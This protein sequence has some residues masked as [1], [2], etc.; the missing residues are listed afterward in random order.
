MNAVSVQYDYFYDMHTQALPSTKECNKF[1]SLLMDWHIH[2]NTRTLPWKSTHDPYKIW[3][4]EILLQQTRTEQGIPYYEKFITHYPTIKDLAAADDTAVFK[5]WEG[6]GYYNRCK[7]M[8]A[9]ARYIA[10][11]LD[12]VFPQDY[13]QILALKGVGAYTAAAIASF[14]FQLPH[15]VVDGNVYRVLSRY[16][17]IETPIDSHEG[18][19]HFAALAAALLDQQSPDLYN[20]A[21]MDLGATVCTPKLAKCD[22]CPLSNRCVALKQDLI[23]LL[24]IKEKKL[25]VKH[26]YFNYFVFLYHDQVWIK[27]RTDKDIWQH[28]HEFYLIESADKYAF[29]WEDYL[30]AHHISYQYVDMAE[31]VQKLTH[32][33]IHAKFIIVELSEI[34]KN[35][36]KENFQPIKSL[37]NFAFPKT[38]V[39]FLN[40]MPYF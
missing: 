1:T 14:A 11:E 17:G 39:N 37:K 20:Q 2:E 23:A 15:A 35:L 27:E 34:P 33:Q 22:I 40:R 18:K 12:G 19:K 13:E 4:S 32:Q 21:I 36:A 24:P 26:R 25:I 29:N 28:L 9:T 30:A 10:A 31:S 3:L 16:F 38:I 5:L 6:L 8:L 7:N